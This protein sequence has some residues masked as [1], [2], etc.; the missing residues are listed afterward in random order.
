MPYDGK[1][2]GLAQI[3]VSQTQLGPGG[4]LATRCRLG[5]KKGRRERGGKHRLRNGKLAISI[6]STQKRGAVKTAE[7]S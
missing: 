7:D 1:I 6:A 3:N 4:A 2:L 5:T